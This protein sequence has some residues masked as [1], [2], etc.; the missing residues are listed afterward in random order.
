MWVFVYTTKMNC[1]VWLQE[2]KRDMNN[3]NARKWVVIRYRYYALPLKI[4]FLYA[5][6]SSSW[7]FLSDQVLENLYIDTQLFNSLAMF[8]KYFYVLLSSV[9]LF[10]LVSR[11]IFRDKKQSVQELDKSQ[12]ALKESIKELTDVYRALNDSTII[13]ITDQKGIIKYVND[14][15]CEISQYSKEEL[16]GQDHRILN[17]GYHSKDFFKQMW[18]TIGTGQTWRGEIRN[19]ARDGSYYW[20]STTIVPFLNEKGKPYQYV[21]IRNDIT[22]KKLAEESLRESEERYRKV[23]ERSPLGI[24]VHQD[25]RIVFANQAIRRIMNI[26]NAIGQSIFTFIHEDY[27]EVSKERMADLTIGTEVPFE[28]MKLIRGDGSVLDAIVG[29]VSFNYEGKPST[30]TMIRD[31]TESKQIQ[32]ELKESEERYGRLVELS[33]ESI[34]IHSNGLIRYANPACVKLLGA[35]SLNQLINQSIVQ[36]AHPHYIRMVNKRV[37]TMKEIGVKI[38]PFEEKIISWDGRIVDVEVTGIT[39]NHEGNLAF[40]MIFRDI[41]RRKKAEEALQQSEEQYRLIAENMTDLVRLVDTNGVVIYASPS[42]EHVLGFS[43]KE[44]EGFSAFDLIHPDDIHQ[45]EAQFENGI[46]AKEDHTAEFRM[47]HARGHWVWIEAHAK[48]V[49]DD[50]DHVHSLQFVGRDITERKILEEK[51]NNMAFSDPLTGFPNRRFFQDKLIQTIKETKRYKRKFALMYMDMDNFKEI[52]D[53]LGH[54]IGD[55]LLIKFSK[56]VQNC[57]RESDILGRQGGDEFIILL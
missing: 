7:I 20:V 10:A 1:D 23:V 32:N 44:I 53:T 56:R 34:V 24:V 15:F 45:L 55:E 4:T 43:P 31:I 42:H 17:S 48:L 33:P 54:D 25:G 16:I 22:E 8:K 18:K 50:H 40:L 35:S 37:E 27:H 14:Q 47:M 52:N 36:F 5:V 29:G 3:G 38:A 28:E 57:I 51:L 19:K 49:L 2:E 39:M 41:T 46:T 26:D 9:I 30:M 12:Q 21:S 13:A 6:L 11:G